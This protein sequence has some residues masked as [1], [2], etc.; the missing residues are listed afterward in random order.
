MT[1]RLLEQYE[2]EILPQ[3]AEKLSAE[4]AANAEAIYAKDAALQEQLKA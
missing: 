3:L 1:P 4:R 2:K